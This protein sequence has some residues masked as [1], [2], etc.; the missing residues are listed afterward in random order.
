MKFLQAKGQIEQP[1]CPN[2]DECYNTEFFN[3]NSDKELKKHINHLK[4]SQRPKSAI[5]TFT[6]FPKTL[7][8]T[9]RV[10]GVREKAFTQW[11]TAFLSNRCCSLSGSGSKIPV[12]WVSRKSQ[13]ITTKITVQY[14]TPLAVRRIKN[15]STFFPS[16]ITRFP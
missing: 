3:Y 11:F 5:R 13:T 9:L 10:F 1:F 4:N 6:S 8:S 12:F 15:N 16:S 2:V 14:T 7:K